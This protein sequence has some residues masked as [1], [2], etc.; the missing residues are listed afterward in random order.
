MPLLWKLSL[1]DPHNFCSPKIVL[2]EIFGRA[3][4]VQHNV[5]L[6]HEAMSNLARLVIVY[7]SGT[8]LT[9]QISVVKNRKDDFHF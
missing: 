5:F 3:F 7:K 8:T 2:A 4:I 1:E 9:W 6:A